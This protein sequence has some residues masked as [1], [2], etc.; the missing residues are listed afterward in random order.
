MK[1]EDY[2]KYAKKT[3]KGEAL[4]LVLTQI[5]AF[6][7]PQK[8][9]KTK[10]NV[11][12]IV[13]LKEGTYLHGIP[14][15]LDNFDWVVK[16]GF[17]SNDFTGTSDGNNKIKNSIGMWNIKKDIAL[18]TY[19]YFYSGFTVS[20]T[21]GRGPMARLITELIPYHNFDEY[22]EKLNDREDVWMYWGEATKEVR[23]MPSLV[24]NKRQ[25][26][27]I[28]NMESDYAKEMK[29]R[30]VWNTDYDP[31]T[32][33]DF[34]DWRYYP[35][36]LDIRFF[37]NPG[38]TDRESAIMFGL[39]SCLIEGVLVGREMEKDKKALKHIKEKL[40]DCYITNIEGKVI[41]S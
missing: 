8:I 23:F 37:R 24:A 6:Y 35:K 41:V 36:F 14:G 10:Y 2:I 32:V 31:E 7:K 3:F 39:P 16:N 20:Y 19:I 38:T 18:R 30:D 12:D 21:L 11:G 17:I 9:E 26:A 25:I 13:Q 27:F 1:K 22:T 15:G 4:D 40:P 29:V 28:L 33:R 34:L 5:N